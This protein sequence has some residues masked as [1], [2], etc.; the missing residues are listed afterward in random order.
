LSATDDLGIVGSAGATVR[1]NSVPVP[2][3]V[4]VPQVT[5]GGSLKLQ[6]QATDPDG[7]AIVFHA[8]ALPAGA[9]LS[10]SGLLA[11]RSAA[12]V[13]SQQIS[14]QASDAYGSSLP[15]Q[16]TLQVIDTSGGSIA[17]APA[18]GSGGGGS[19]AG[20]L[21]LLAGGVLAVARRWRRR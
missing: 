4:S 14:W 5:F 2:L 11:W 20:D 15:A 9:T 16:F 19:M 21:M 7:D 13:G 1:V 6:L 18:G 10:A 3:P 12:P 17:A 8:S